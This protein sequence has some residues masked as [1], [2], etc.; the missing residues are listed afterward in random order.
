MSHTCPTC[1]AVR[2]CFEPSKVLGNVSASEAAIA[3]ARARM[4]ELE[5]Q[6]ANLETDLAGAQRALTYQ[7]ARAEKAEAEVVALVR[8]HGP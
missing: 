2:G 4:L 3:A 7:R 5:R 8:K 6:V 1:G